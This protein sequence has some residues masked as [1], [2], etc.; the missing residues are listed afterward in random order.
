LHTKFKKPKNLKFGLLGFLGLLKNLLKTKVFQSKF[1]ALMS[2]RRLLNH[3]SRLFP[4][5]P[6]L[7][8][9]QRVNLYYSGIRFLIRPMHQL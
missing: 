1:L 5:V 9:C 8:H 7:M 3:Y 4:S 2:A 6:A